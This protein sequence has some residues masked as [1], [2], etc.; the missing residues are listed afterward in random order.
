MELI[1]AIHNLRPAHLGCVATI[2]KFDGVH[3]GHQQI[4]R[5]LKVKASAMG[6][7]SLVILFEPHPAEF[8]VPEKA[9]AR[10]NSLAT[11]LEYLAQQQIDRVLCLNFNQKLSAVPADDFIA[12]LLVN[13]L[14]VAHFVVGDDFRFGQGRKG[15]F[16]LLQQRGQ[17][18]G[19]AVEKS[20]TL[21][22]DDERVSSTKIRQLLAEHNFSRAAQLLGR[23]FSMKGRVVHGQKLARTLGV[24]TANIKTPKHNLPLK[25]VFAV[26]AT[27]A[28][29]T[30]YQA[31]AN[32]GNRPTVN[33]LKP[34]LE[35]HMF[36]FEQ[37]IYG[38][39]LTVEFN[40]Y[41]RAE[42]KF[43]DLDQ[44]K[45]AIFNDIEMAK[46]YFASLNQ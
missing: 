27:T 37:Q 31:V 46:Q 42:Q 7:P 18:F 2:G 8:F 6:L 15:S 9:P 21:M 41:L 30:I 26:T 11:K 16:E 22:D 35:V 19:F 44:L 43:A 36:D 13:K 34:V 17:E 12:A 5:Q 14:A 25:G 20:Q 23:P 40:H 32:L 33:G 1:R 28:A 4:L 39:K 45:L 38:Q 3:L 24:P 29:G 10:L